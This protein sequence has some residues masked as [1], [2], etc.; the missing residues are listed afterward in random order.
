M[1]ALKKA[2]SAPATAPRALPFSAFRDPEVYD[3][4]MEKAFCGDWVAVCSERELTEPGSY[5]SQ[6]IGNEPI[7]VIRGADG[8]IRAM[9]NNC[10]HRGT[11]LLDRGFGKL[12]GTSI[13]CP[14]HAWTYSDR[15]EL[16]GVPYPGSVDV[17]KAEHCLPTYPIETFLGVV[18]VNVDGNAQ[19]LSERLA[20]IDKTLRGYDLD[21]YTALAP[22]YAAES[23]GSTGR[24]R[25]VE[26]N[27]K[28]VMAN[29]IEP[30]HLFKLH[31]TTLE[32]LYPTKDHIYLE[33]SSEWT[34]IGGN[35]VT[36]PELYPWEPDCMTEFERGR[37][38]LISVP[39]SF[40]A[41]VSRD[42]WYYAIAHPDGVDRTL[43]GGGGFM[44][45]ELYDER[46]AN[47]EQVDALVE[48]FNAEDL[49]IMERGQ[50]SMRSRRATGG[51]LVQSER[52][53]GDLHRF[54]ASR[55]FGIA[56][57]PFHSEADD[58]MR[59]LAAAA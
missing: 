5:F 49:W 4:E 38:L 19:P 42:E 51:P 8:R 18:F 41:I 34:V 12:A 32:P 31:E 59:R 13:I 54:L 48:A 57:E 45:P 37:Y 7:A 26:A 53:L 2:L 6:F 43:F 35:Y 30:Y 56:P 46:V 15:G 52:I 9:S 20:G 55:M 17:D 24:S 3:L 10:R 40:V 22:G 39:P 14:Y 33:G 27:W 25:Q 36:H 21:R 50:L 28:L 11:M 58:H 47:R 23:P 44:P 29:A 1:K 16:R